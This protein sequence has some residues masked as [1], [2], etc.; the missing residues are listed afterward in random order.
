M[1]TLNLTKIGNINTSLYR[2]LLKPNANLTHPLFLLQAPK[3]IQH[4]KNSTVVD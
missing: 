1:L 3:S 2:Y 4:Q